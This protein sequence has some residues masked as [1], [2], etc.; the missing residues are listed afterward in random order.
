MAPR[1]LSSVRL[2]AACAAF[3]TLASIPVVLGQSKAPDAAA[4]WPKTP[5]GDPDLQG[6]WTFATITPLE[7]PAKYGDREFLTPEEVASITQESE[8]RANSDRRGK[9]TREEDVG[10]AYDQFWWD[11]GGALNR[12]SLVV[13]P[14]DGRLPYTPEGRAR[15]AE[16][17]KRGFDSWEDRSPSERCIVYRPVPVR[18][19]GYN[20]N[21]VIVQSPGYL[22]MYQEQIHEVRIIPLD[23][24]P[25]LGQGI[26]PWLGDSRGR[27]EGNTLVVETKNFNPLT[28]YEGSGGDRVVVEKFTP[29]DAKT[30]RYDFTV[31]DPATWTQPWTGTMPWSRLDEH[32]YEYACHEGNYAMVHMLQGA[33]NLEKKAAQP[34]PARKGTR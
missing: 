32:V 29:V 8:Q 11:R 26:R 33:R 7:R 25:H 24:R 6:T 3:A 12:T 5:W 10:L 23:G 20:N 30:M 21:Q 4:Q 31:T 27:W 1:H 34:R 2:L 16:Q 22:A 9:L 28:E 14:R 17:E 18:S 13:D 15:R 19:T